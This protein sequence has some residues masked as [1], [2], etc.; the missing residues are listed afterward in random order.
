MNDSFLVEHEHAHAPDDSNPYL[1]FVQV[2][3]HYIVFHLIDEWIFKFI[4]LVLFRSSNSRLSQNKDFPNQNSA[5]DYFY[6]YEFESFDAAFKFLSLKFRKKKY[7]YI[8]C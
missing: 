3:Y 2:S 5:K 4:K 1:L 6:E 8:S 7:I